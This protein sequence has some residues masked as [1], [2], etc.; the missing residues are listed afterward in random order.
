MPTDSEN[1]IPRAVLTAILAKVLSV[2]KKYAHEL[3]GVRNERREKVK[4]AIN[5]VVAERMEK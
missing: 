1:E 3:K 4:E 5:S 2:Q